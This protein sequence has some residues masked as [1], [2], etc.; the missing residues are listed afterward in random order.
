[1]IALPRKS[2]YFLKNTSW[3][4][5]SALYYTL[6]GREDLPARFLLGQRIRVDFEVICA[7]FK[8]SVLPFQHGGDRRRQIAVHTRNQ[9]T[10]PPVI[11]AFLV[12]RDL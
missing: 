4:R 6:H 2:G 5:I 7:V 3:K 12:F 10:S 8:L 11:S 9:H 1:M